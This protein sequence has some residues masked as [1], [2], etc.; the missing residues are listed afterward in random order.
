MPKKPKNAYFLFLSELDLKGSTKERNKRS[1][2]LWA[3]QSPEEKQKY[4]DRAKEDADKFNA[5]CASEEG[6]KII[7]ERHRILNECRA[8]SREALADAVRGKAIPLETT[9]VKRSRPTS[10]RASPPSASAP[11]SKAAAAPSWDEA[12]VLEA[13]KSDLLSQLRNLASRPEVAA[14]G[15]SPQELLDALKANQGMVNAAK[16][17]LISS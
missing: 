12:V 14:L 11:A 3:A 7:S 2:E 9:P 10:S 15:R 6:E 8:T 5:W 1:T 4:V 16:H 13:E 17:S